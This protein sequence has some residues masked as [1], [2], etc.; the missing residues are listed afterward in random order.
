MQQGNVQQA[1]FR[2]A[3]LTCPPPTA[4]VLYLRD[5]QLSGEIPQGWQLPINMTVR[6]ERGAPPHTPS[7]LYC[8]KGRKPQ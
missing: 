8:T 2:G 7:S 6:M 3:S 5:N 1:C 4:Q